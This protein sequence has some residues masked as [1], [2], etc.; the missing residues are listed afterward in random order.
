[1]MGR[2]IMTFFPNASFFCGIALF[3]LFYLSFSVS[4]SAEISE[5]GSVTNIEVQVFDMPATPLGIA[6]GSWLHMDWFSGDNFML[7]GKAMIPW[8]LS[9]SDIG[10]VIA[11]GGLAFVFHK[12]FD[13]AAKYSQLINVDR[14][15]YQTV[16]TYE[17]STTRAVFLHTLSGGYRKYSID[18]TDNSQYDPNP[19]FA[20][21][22]SMVYFG[23]RYVSFYDVV[24]PI[25]EFD[26]HI[27]GLLI[28]SDR[29]S[30]A[31]IS[32]NT[33]FGAEIG[34]GWYFLSLNYTY[35][36]DAHMFDFGA[37]RLS[38]QF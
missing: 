10:G 31:D 30:G 25:Q 21:K 28:F 36:G 3:S 20:M 27:Y 29:V 23:Y 13:P 22:D 24:M 32:R 5:N 26:F 17:I 35:L 8:Y 9:G 18:I 12:T 34:F 6:F 4:V 16:Y 33:L 11:E 19:P 38:F 2:S 1:M 7:H 37:L 14:G 15:A